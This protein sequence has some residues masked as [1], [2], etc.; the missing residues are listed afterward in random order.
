MTK[1]WLLLLPLVIGGCTYNAK[2]HKTSF[3]PF[4]APVHE[5]A[6][7]IASDVKECGVTNSKGC[8]IKTASDGYEQ[9]K[10]G[11][12]SNEELDAHI[13]RLKKKNE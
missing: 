2:T 8:T 9:S 11:A 7:T 13:Q 5:M 4:G 10:I 6:E 3:T 12:M 1:V